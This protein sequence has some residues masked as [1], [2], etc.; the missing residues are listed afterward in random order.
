MSSLKALDNIDLAIDPIGLDYYFNYG[1]IPAP[2]SAYKHIRKLPPGHNLIVDV[3]TRRVQ[4]I[5]PYWHPLTAT[6]PTCRSEGEWIEAIEAKIE[7]A[8]KVRLISDVPLGAFLSGGLD[9]SLVVSKMAG[10][11]TQP[12]ETFTIGFGHEEFDERDYAKA[13]AG[14]YSTHHHV[15]VVEPDAVALLPKLV[16]SFGEPFADASAI[17]TYYVASMARKHITVAL[18]GDGG[19]EVFAGYTRYYRLHQYRHWQ[20]IP[21]SLRRNLQALG[22]CLPEHIPGYGLLQRQAYD[23]I[24]LYRELVA[25]FTQQEQTQLYTPAFKDLLNR[26]SQVYFERILDEQS[27]RAA[28]P[29]TQLQAIDLNSYLPGDILTKVDRTTML[30]SLEARVS[31]LDHELIELALSCPAAIRFKNGTLKYLTKQIL[32]GK[33][34]EKVLR[35][36]KQGFGLPLSHWFRNEWKETLQAQL[37]DQ[38][39]DNFL[40]VAW[41][42]RML[43]L[44]QKGGRD[45]GRKLYSILFYQTWKTS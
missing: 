3:P 43:D 10:L 28:D 37:N 7:E 23:R 15:E 42:Q 20:H 45:F 38:T 14:H 9:S 40:D 1:Y 17:P 8:I 5:T 6:A 4:S 44:H 18:S 21:Q 41:I 31:L 26:E 11:M 25:S 22:R 29:I 35:H 24:D 19:D 12:V 2:F 39:G 33:A 36:S 16:D 34:P 27:A 30:S 32:A 13:L